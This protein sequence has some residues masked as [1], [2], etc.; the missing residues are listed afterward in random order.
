MIKFESNVIRE[1][2]EKL[3]VIL[4]DKKYLVEFIAGL[5]RNNKEEI[6]NA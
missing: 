4:E 6:T 2:E 5:T 1:A 3:K